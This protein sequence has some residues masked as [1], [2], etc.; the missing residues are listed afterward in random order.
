MENEDK[1]KDYY[2][3]YWKDFKDLQFEQKHFSTDAQDYYFVE[4]HSDFLTG[5]FSKAPGKF[6]LNVG[7]GKGT[8]SL[9]LERRGFR[10]VNLDYLD[11]ALFLTRGFYNKAGKKPLLV[12]GDINSLPFKRESFDIV[13]NF[14]VIEHFA[15]IQPAY[16][17]MARILKRKGILHSEVITK[18]LSVHTIERLTAILFSFFYNLLAF[19]IKKLFRLIKT[20]YQNEDFYENSYEQEYYSATLRNSGISKLRCLGI[21]PYPFLRLPRTLD[22][23]YGRIVVRAVNSFLNKNQISLSRSMFFRKWCT[24]WLFYGVK[25]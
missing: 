5:I 3:K 6:I 8:H 10:V 4:S 11:G 1:I 14:G 13:M 7:C 18:R 22:S 20:S 12:R 24:I 17:E 19:R 16:N 2:L 25:E 21:R 9:P 23:L 15:D